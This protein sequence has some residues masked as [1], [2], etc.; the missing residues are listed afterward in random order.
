VLEDKAK[1][2]GPK[3]ENDDKD[4]QKHQGR[5]QGHEAEDKG[6]DLRPSLRPRPKNSKSKPITSK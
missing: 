2:M 4:L 3:N 5:G 1:D 6:K